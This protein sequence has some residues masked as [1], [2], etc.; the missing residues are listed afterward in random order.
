MI[1]CVAYRKV[2]V[3]F[4]VGGQWCFV[5]RLLMLYVMRLSLCHCRHQLKLQ[6]Q[7]QQ[8]QPKHQEV[9]DRWQLQRRHPLWLRQRHLWSK[10]CLCQWWCRCQRDRSLCQLSKCQSQQHQMSKCQSQQHLSQMNHRRHLNR[11]SQVSEH[12]SATGYP[13]QPSPHYYKASST[14]QWHSPITRQRQK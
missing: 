13:A 5:L 7:H 1:V 8:R 3:K 4:G 6:L 11:R 14:L 2:I 10:L 9:Q 12:G